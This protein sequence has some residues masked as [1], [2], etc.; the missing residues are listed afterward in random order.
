MKKFSVL[1]VLAFAFCLFYA[2]KHEPI[3]PTREVSY[4]D[5]I[6]PIV[7]GSCQHAGC[8]DPNDPNA[9]FPLDSI[10]S[11]LNDYVR[12][13]DPEDSDLYE[14]ITDDDPDDRMPQPPY[15]PLTERQIQLIYIWI[16]QGAKD[17]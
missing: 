15:Q 14:R 12:P 3:L 4:H 1:F 11:E 17:N 2:C 8:H 13:G 10:V 9:E 5:D 6:L 16:A 7:R